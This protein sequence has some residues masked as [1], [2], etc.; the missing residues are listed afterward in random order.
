MRKKLVKAEKIRV[1]IAPSPTGPLHIGTA[2]SALFNYLFA[3]KNKGDFILRIEDTDAQ[4]SNLK[5]T[6]EIIESLKWLGID[7]QEGPD[8]DGKFGPYKQ[9]QRL[10]IYEKYIKKLL[11][12]EKAYY[13]FCSEEELEAIKQEQMARGVAPH[14]TG[15]CRK[16]SEKE[17]GKNLEQK[18][19]SVI[20]LKVSTKKIKFDD[21]IRGK[22]E[23]D[24]GL[25]GDFIIAKDSKSP[26]YNLAVVIDDYEMQ[27]SDVIRGEDHI[28]NTPK[29]ILIQEALGFYQPVYAHLPLILAPDRTKLS[30]RH[31]AFSLA[32][33]KEQGYLPEA[34]INFM[35]LLGWNPGRNMEI[36]TLSGLIKE[37]SIERVQK[38]G[39]IFNIQ[40][41]DSI[42][43]FYIRQKTT[44]KLTL[45]CIPFLI[46]AK[47]IEKNGNGY[48]IT[49]TGEGISL[50]T[51]E[52]IIE[53]YKA[54]MKKLS[55]IVEI[56][57]F[58]FK[59]KLA[60]SKDLLKWNQMSDKDIEKSLS[61][62]EKILSSIET[63][64]LKNLEKI[65]IEEAVK[66]TLE[67][68]Y[69]ENNRGFLLWPLRV[70]L[71]GKKASAS[72][73]EIA[74]VLGKEKTL[75]RIKEAKKLLV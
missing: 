40:K 8:V 70:S 35:A 5:W 50:A 65:L 42:N 47:L 39:A 41:L 16:L 20:R 13:C 68:N 54:R 55:E 24:A 74:E 59:E 57:D 61:A 21:L 12:D 22:I 3:K 72:P 63:W 27:I 69:P 36:F 23:F 56:A 67:N 38:S 29:Q 28:S 73:F 44:D 66:F 43:S 37:F 52:K 19:S 51:M 25:L 2:R 31:G 18:K 48:K 46:S 11:D 15:K 30:K 7:W 75:Q 1:R 45:L 26:L 6:E 33:Y 10:D 17:R 34:V 53:G 58:F 9:S 62:S 4:R 60:Y 71:S 32:E 64:N 49:Q 14:Y